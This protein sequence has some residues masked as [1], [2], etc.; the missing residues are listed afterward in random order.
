MIRFARDLTRMIAAASL[1]IGSVGIT[2]AAGALA[3][4]TCG[5]YGYSFGFPEEGAAQ[6][7]ALEKCTGTGCKVVATIRK[8]CAAFAVDGH[9]ACGPHGYAVTARLGAAQNTAMS[10]CYRFG[11]KDCV[12]RAWACDV[13]G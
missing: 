13:K 2:Q 6:S 3:I 5:A 10:Y 12:I 9:N 1:L 11:G 8:G 7:A 4:G